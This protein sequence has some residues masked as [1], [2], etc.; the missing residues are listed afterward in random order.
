MV[1]SKPL[2]ERLLNWLFL[3]KKTVRQGGLIHELDHRRVTDE[4]IEE[5][6]KKVT[7]KTKGYRNG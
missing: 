6:K 7:A 3:R 5:V 2:G 4:A 1:V